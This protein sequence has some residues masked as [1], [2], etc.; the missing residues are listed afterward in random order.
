MN[1]D[2]WIL[3]PEHRG[4][5]VAQGKCGAHYK[6]P[7]S[8]LPLNRPCELGVQWVHVKSVFVPGVA[9]MFAAKQTHIRTLEDAI[10]DDFDDSGWVMW[11]TDYI[12]EVR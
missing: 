1:K 9:P 4:T 5:A 3:H 12:L 2:V 7:K 11:C 8:K 10:T 6:M